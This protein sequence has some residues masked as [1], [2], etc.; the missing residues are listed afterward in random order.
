MTSKLEAGYKLFNELH[1]EHAGEQLINAICD[2]CHD[3][4]NI[5]AE[6]GF[7]TIFNRSGLDIKTRELI[8]IGLCAAL[9]D[10]ESQLL[11]HIDAALRCGATQEECIET[12]LQTSLYAGFARVTNA[13]LATKKILK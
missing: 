4:A 13:L 10:M 3:Y 6:F 7:G 9:G 1:G 8:V 11:A 2:I 12:I 5:T